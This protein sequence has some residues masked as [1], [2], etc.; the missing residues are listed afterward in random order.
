[1]PNSNKSTPSDELRRVQ[2]NKRA[3]GGEDR[4]KTNKD[5]S[6]VEEGKLGNP[7]PGD[8]SSGRDWTL[9]AFESTKSTHETRDANKFADGPSDPARQIRPPLEGRARRSIPYL[10]ATLKR[11]ISSSVPLSTVHRLPF[12]TGHISRRYSKTNKERDGAAA[13]RPRGPRERMNESTAE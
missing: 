13:K 1:M 11:S 5:E 8:W 9:A 12:D 7:L 3:P 6:N 10:P 2:T 4:D